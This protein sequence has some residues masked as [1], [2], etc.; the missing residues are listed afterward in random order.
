[1]IYLAMSDILVSAVNPLGIY[2]FASDR[3]ID[4]IPYWKQLCLIKGFFETIA[5]HAC[6]MSYMLLSVDR[7]AILYILEIIFTVS[8]RY[9]TYNDFM[10]GVTA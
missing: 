8:N 7:Y 5:T 3:I 6:Q 1:M 2:I 4:R 9:T 10:N